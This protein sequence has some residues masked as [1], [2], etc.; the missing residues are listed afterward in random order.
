MYMVSFLR[1]LLQPALVP[2]NKLTA[3]C[4]AIAFAPLWLRKNSKGLLAL[5]EEGEMPALAVNVVQA[6]IEEYN[7]LFQWT[8]EEEMVDHRTAAETAT[9]RESKHVEAFNAVVAER[10]KLQCMQVKALDFMSGKKELRRFFKGWQTITRTNNLLVDRGD[11]R[12]QLRY[13][14]GVLRAEHQRRVAAES[15]VM[16]LRAAL[17][18]LQFKYQILSIVGPGGGGG[19]GGSG[20]AESGATMIERLASKGASFQD[21][22]QEIAALMRMDGARGFG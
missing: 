1:R 10:S 22:I 15:E 21:D 4:L 12:E 11:P 6:M 8:N 16:R 18:D 9:E 13:M 3:Q 19:G 5:E 2:S 20:G 17:E 7:E 14:E